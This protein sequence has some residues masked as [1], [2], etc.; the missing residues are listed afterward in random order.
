MTYIPATHE[1]SLISSVAIRVF[2]SGEETNLIR[3]VGALAENPRL[4]GKP[5]CIVAEDPKIRW[6]NMTFF[7]IASMS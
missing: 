6:K 7:H 1:G 5:T 2:K 3:G 4:T